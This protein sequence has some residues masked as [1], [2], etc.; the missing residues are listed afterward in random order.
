MNSVKE[1]FQKNLNEKVL[2]EKTVRDFVVT[3]R[4]NSWTT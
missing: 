2:I 1:V 4:E 3:Q